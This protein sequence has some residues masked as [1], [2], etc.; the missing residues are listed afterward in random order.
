MEDIKT[1]LEITNHIVTLIILLVIV[2]FQKIFGFIF[3]IFKNNSPDIGPV[4][5]SLGKRYKIYAL[6]IYEKD[7]SNVTGYSRLGASNHT[8]EDQWNK[9][10]SIKSNFLNLRHEVIPKNKDIILVVKI[11]RNQNDDIK[12]ISFNKN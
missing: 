8:R 9:I 2:P 12:T 7:D 4:F 10:I 3:N 5:W 1:L 11:K 6:T